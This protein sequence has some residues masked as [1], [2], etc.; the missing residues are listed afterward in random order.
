MSPL[1]DYGQLKINIYNSYR[2]APEDEPFRLPT[3]EGNIV[4][5]KQ[6]DEIDDYAKWDVVEE[7][8]MSVAGTSYRI[9]NVMRFMAGHLRRIKLIDAPIPKFPHA[10][11]VY[12][13]WYEDGDTSYEEQLGY[14]PNDYAK[15][16]NKQIKKL[17]RFLL[18]GKLTHMFFPTDEKPSPGLLIDVTLFQPALPRFKLKGIGKDTGRKRRHTYIA[19]NVEDAIM[20]AQ[21]DGI[22]V[23]MNTIKRIT[24]K[25]IQPQDEIEPLKQAIK[26]KPDDANEHYKLGVAHF[27]FRHYRDA[28]DAFKQAI[29]I[30][31]DYADA[32]HFLGDAYVKCNYYQE[33]IDSYKQAIRLKPDDANA[34]YSLAVAYMLFGD[35]DGVM[36]EYK[37]LQNLNAKKAKIVSSFIHK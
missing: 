7:E 12:G 8:N 35:Q 28:I 24:P 26:T 16:L 18:V 20:Q 13:K 23:E 25:F 11:A 19:K 33:A 36:E 29:E 22:I 3:D 21:K 6:Q 37:I 4:R 2:E 17:S 34:H 31:P 32:H 30:K 15:Y 14:I 27:G 10:I 5:I 1:K 9:D